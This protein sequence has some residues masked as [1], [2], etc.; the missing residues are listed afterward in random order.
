MIVSES[1]FVLICMGFLVIVLSFL[2]AMG[3]MIYASFEIRKAAAAFREFMERSGEKLAPV[4]DEAEKT[5]KSVR[6]VSDDMAKT[7]GNIS[8]L[9]G[10][11]YDITS[12][13]RAV[14]GLLNDLRNGLFLRKAGLKAGL[15]A[16]AAVLIQRI[17]ERRS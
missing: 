8:S 10:A 5:L 9:T 12:N 1:W 15:R 2:V 6:G 14:S 3:F 17:N 11:V 16:A 13:L 4:L 7:T